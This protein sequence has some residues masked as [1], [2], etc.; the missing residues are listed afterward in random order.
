MT[1]DEDNL[2][3]DREA[4]ALRMIKGTIEADKIHKLIAISNVESTSGLEGTA[5]F[6]GI[7]KDQ[8]KLTQAYL[9]FA[10]PKDAKFTFV[11]TGPA[12]D[13]SIGK[14][15]EAAFLSLHIK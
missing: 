5:I 6:F 3:I 1:V 9:I 8:L 12:G 7:E 15:I 11:I 13:E 2:P 10:G 4:F 14:A